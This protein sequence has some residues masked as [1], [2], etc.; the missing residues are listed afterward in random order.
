[1]VLGGEGRNAYLT[2]R[3]DYYPFYEVAN[4]ELPA[5]ARVWLINTRRDTY[6]LDRSYVA[7]FMFEDYTLGQWVRAARDPAVCGATITSCAK[8]DCGSWM[9]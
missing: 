7:D 5:T 8:G 9:I 1:M 3:L 2:R 4:R 6:L